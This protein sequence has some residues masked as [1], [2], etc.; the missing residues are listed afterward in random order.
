MT[1]Y[2]VL[3][4]LIQCLAYGV[5]A[6]AYGYLPRCQPQS[7]SNYQQGAASATGTHQNRPLQGKYGSSASFNKQ[8]VAVTSPSTTHIPDQMQRVIAYLS[9]QNHTINQNHC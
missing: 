9:S 3:Q 1:H 6:L 5:V 8:A 2:H 7:Q 4:K